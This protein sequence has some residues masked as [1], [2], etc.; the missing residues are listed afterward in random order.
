MILLYY[1]RQI[2]RGLVKIKVS[3][4]VRLTWSRSS[5]NDYHHDKAERWKNMANSF[6]GGL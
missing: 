5:L 4:A 1:W 3:Q 2:C 6:T